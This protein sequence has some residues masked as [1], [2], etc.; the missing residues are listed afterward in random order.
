MSC[1]RVKKTFRVGGEES[2][3]AVGHTGSPEPGHRTRRE[4][5]SQS[6]WDLCPDPPSS[7][8]PEGYRNSLGGGGGGGL[9]L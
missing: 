9:S 5:G 8:Q 2:G 7:Q 3:P 1:L 4:A 6:S